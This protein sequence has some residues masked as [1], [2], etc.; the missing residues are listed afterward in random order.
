MSDKS[1]HNHIPLE[2]GL[3]DPSYEHDACGTGFVASI[4]GRASHAIIQMAVQ[5]VRNLTHRGAV[6]ADGKTGD[7]AGVLTQ[8][9]HKLFGRVL[10]EM[11]SALPHDPH[12]LAVG[13][14]FLPPSDSERCQ[15]IIEDV[16]KQHGLALLGWRPVP[17]DVTALGDKA[18]ETMP[19]IS[20]LM[21]SRG[22]GIPRERFGQALYLA[23]RQMEAQVA[24]A[25]VQGFYTPSFSNR[26]MVYKGLLVAPQL[27]HLYHDL[28]DPDFET[29]LAVFH[30]RYSTNTLPNWRNA[31]PFRFLAHN[32]EINTLQ[33]NVNWIRA[34]EPELTSSLWGDDIRA[35]L[36][37]VQ[38]GGSDS[39]NLDNVLEVLVASGRDVLH[40]MTMLIPEAWENMP[41][42]DPQW[43]A[44]YEYHASITEPWD[45]PA[46]IAFT[47][48]VIAA[49]TLD[50]NGLR[51]ARYKVTDD[52]IV[53]MA[54]EVGVVEADESRVVEKGRLG[55]GQ[56]IAVDT[57]NRRL[58]KNKDIKDMLSSRK[59]YAQW[60]ADN[61]VRLED[62]VKRLNG[63]PIPLE[64]PDLAT[65]RAF[66]YTSEEMDL[67]LG[68][69]AK[70]A[71]EPVGSMGD[72]TPLAVLATK[73]R[74]LYTYF[75]QRFAQVTNPPI[76][77][78][79][80][81]IVMSLNTYLGRRHSLL[82]ESPEHA[83]L[84]ALS[85]VVLDN[86]EMSALKGIGHPDLRVEVIP[87]LFPASEGPSALKKALDEVCSRAIQAVDEGATI[88]ILSDRGVDAGHAPIPML[89]AVGGVHHQLIRQGKRMKAS[90][91][92]ETGEARE[93]HQMACLIGFG[94]SAINPYLGLQTIV[95]LIEEDKMPEVGVEKALANYVKTI[96]KQIL[97]ITSK[98][99]ISAIS[100]YHGAQIF[101]ALGI[102]QE[103]IAY[104][105]H[106]TP[107][108]IGGVGFE[109]IGRETLARHN[110]AF[111]TQHDELDDYGYYRFRKDGEPHS[112]NPA[113]VR[114]IHKA[115]ETGS[116]DDYQRYLDEIKGLAPVYLRDLLDIAPYGPPV[117]LDE[118]EPAANI[119]CRF[120]TGSM[121]LGALSPEAH[122]T[123]A[124]GMN[125]LNGKSNTG[126]GGEDPARYR[127][128]DEK[129]Y[130]ANSRGKQVA[131]G[132]FGVTPEYLAM[133]DELEIKM[134]QGSKPG[135]G[136]QLPG[137]KVV[138]YIARLRHT[139]PG[140]TLISPPP[141]HDIY[142]IEDLA[143]LIYDLKIANP[144][145]RVAV[146]LVAE[147]GVGT[148]AAGVAKGYADVVQ[149]SGM[150][151]GTGAS[152]LISIKNAGCP[153]ELGVAEAQQTLVR[154][155][156]RGR[157]ILRTDGGMRS[158]RDVLVAAILGAE[159]YGF[160]TGALV[161]IGCK[162]ARQCHLNTCPVGVATQDPRLR[163][164]FKGTPEDLV[165][166]M[167]FIAEELRQMMASLGIRRLDEVIGH[168]ELLRQVEIPG[169]P[170]ANTLDLSKLL[171]GPSPD[172]TVARRRAQERNDRPGDA[173]FDE[174]IRPELQV[175]LD[176]G[177]RVSATYPIRNANRTVGARLSHYVARRVG[178]AGLSEGAIDLTL[179]G[180]AGQSFGA[181]LT[182][183]FRFTLWGEANDYV[184]KGMAGGQ[185]VLRPP[186]G[187]RYLPHENVIMGN[188]VLYG[189]TGGY[190]FASGRA[191]ER[192]AVRNSGAWAVVEG[193]G[194][195]C[196]EYMTGGV[197]VVLGEVGRNVGA[198]MSG[199][200]AFI[201]DSALPSKHNPEMVEL[202]RV[203]EQDDVEILHTLLQ[204]HL[205]NTASPRA[206]ELLRHWPRSLSLF[207][208][209]SPKATVAPPPPR[210]EQRARR[211]A[212]VAQ[213]GG[214][215]H[216]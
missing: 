148:I 122:E 175:A 214:R 167:F 187:A 36:P 105:F 48:G 90:I 9:P 35:L 198:G 28:K 183:G 95:K 129:G 91:V 126:E 142:S 197:V 137:H 77:Y 170:K 211:N 93:M 44:F 136:G 56:M 189:A 8:I 125:Y 154:N 153:W 98:M 55:P 20:H 24:R 84:I 190:L 152:P 156:L 11:G 171:A 159:E 89:L 96:E 114:L 88:L 21:V 5:S 200:M 79:R 144:R 65:Q 185:L 202:S 94:A 177:P 66:G 63:T 92:A 149:V 32:G 52:G 147:A 195:H 39:A 215:R 75:K 208:K 181:F 207:W 47:D 104:C 176:G 213:G 18:R 27:D 80:E 58:L 72:D 191:G 123:L 209:V 14:M 10:R 109:D 38:D 124:K 117:P 112:F 50:R 81:Q 151:G 59:P 163:E 192:F 128:V 210:E 135:E 33:G 71:I 34:K 199:G 82:E 138:D 74:L 100:G 169:H 172:D 103:V 158:A 182:P 73:P 1:E 132:R 22:E 186:E 155:G 127:T 86:Q 99:G 118:V 134:A 102:G 179:R 164:K 131:S 130:S 17:V 106:G 201:M 51:P 15:R 110:R 31:Q 6:S 203:E 120:T 37:I 143:Q 53:L 133:A 62:V 101:E 2:Q 12:D 196:C 69:M 184:G 194:D 57:Q 139:Q 146:K 205:D 87:C 145:A 30:Q 113:M 45:G 25:G 49:A 216:G 40:A 204:R 174:A 193:A 54:S 19:R 160:G 16:I 111:A 162:M 121:S 76:D 67:V 42:L 85:S 108:P 46:A 41:N 168:P 23:R 97:K 78:L 43:K 83:R 116:A 29:A 26:S 173:P 157:V 68:P 7:G 64:K 165:R 166:F 107:S 141:H 61:M 188:T 212:L 60:L 206:S 119:V 161:A 3:Y 115:I 150:E 140:V 180:S 70:K 13:V 178:D 4:E